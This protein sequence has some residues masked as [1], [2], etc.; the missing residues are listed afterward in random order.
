[1]S[2]V[3]GVDWDSLG[4]LMDIPYSEREEIRVNHVEYP[5]FS[6]KAEKTF[7]LLIGRDDFGR[8]DLEKC[9]EELGRNDLRHEMLPVPEDEVFKVLIKPWA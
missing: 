4:G 6:K 5:N 2:R 1:M 8:R 7:A 9:I 3:I